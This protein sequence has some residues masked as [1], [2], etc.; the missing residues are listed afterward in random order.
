M[1]RGFPDLLRLLQARA[2]EASLLDSEYVVQLTD[3]GYQIR[4]EIRE[5]FILKNKIHIFQ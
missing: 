3:C 5:N 4:D 1:Y 2:L